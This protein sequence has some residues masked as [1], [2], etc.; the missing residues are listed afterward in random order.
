MQDRLFNKEKL[1]KKSLLIFFSCVSLSFSLSAQY[2]ADGFYRVKNAGSERFLY[3]TDDK[4]HVDIKG[5][6]PDYDLDAIVLRKGIDHTI[7]DPSTII[8]VS[9]K[10]GYEYDLTCQGTGIKKMTG[11][12]VTLRQDNSVKT[13]YSVGATQAGIT[14]YLADKKHDSYEYGIIDIESGKPYNQWDVISLN[15]SS[16]N[17]FGL[18]PSVEANGQKYAP[19]FA[20][21]GFE[22]ASS[23]MNVYYISEVNEEKGIVCMKELNGTVPNNTPVFVECGSSSASDNRLSIV[24]NT[25][26]FS[27][28][29]LKGVYFNFSNQF[30]KEGRIPEAPKGQEK[31]YKYSVQLHKNQVAYNPLTMR[32]L[33]VSPEG[34]LAYVKDS[35]LDYLPAN[36][37]YLLVTEN[38][39]DYLL[40]L[41]EEDFKVSSIEQLTSDVSDREVYNL[42]GKKVSS[43]RS[44]PV[45]IYIINGKK[46]VV[47]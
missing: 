17:Y 46:T 3:L 20:E 43:N 36:Q 45:G 15:A 19:F 41:S 5:A 27:G 13:R 39:P 7:S 22:P 35:N 6:N 29:V 2:L 37:S 10:S 9:R 34:K 42:L 44:L 11:R 16:D 12:L 33:G 23:G 4:G 28:N 26:S 18:V 32:V 24:N 40:V 25:S 14:K 1:M 38:A 8:Y 31:F 47:R 21:F 30:L